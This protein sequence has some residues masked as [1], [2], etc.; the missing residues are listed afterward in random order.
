MSFCLKPAERLKWNHLL[1]LKYHLQLIYQMWAAI[2][3]RLYLVFSEDPWRM[4]NPQISNLVIVKVTETKSNFWHIWGS[5]TLNLSVSLIEVPVNVR[6]GSTTTSL[7]I[8]HLDNY[9]TQLFRLRD[10][11]PLLFGALLISMWSYVHI[12]SSLWQPHHLH[13]FFDWIYLTLII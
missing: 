3:H 8:V 10:D 5:I 2:V 1:T 12:F 7:K 9:P 4:I 6:C 11:S 13:S